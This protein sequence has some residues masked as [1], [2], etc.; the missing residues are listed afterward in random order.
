MDLKIGGICFTAWTI[1]LKTI[2]IENILLKSC[3]CGILFSVFGTK[4]WSTTTY[5]SIPYIYS[6]HGSIHGCSFVR[7]IFSIR[8]SHWFFTNKI[9]S[10]CRCHLYFLFYNRWHEGCYIHWCVSGNLSA[11]INYF[12]FCLKCYFKIISVSTLAKEQM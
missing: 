3:W 9:H 4:I 7:P 12:V 10:D 5:Y 1:I 2:I 11:L 6:L 8:S